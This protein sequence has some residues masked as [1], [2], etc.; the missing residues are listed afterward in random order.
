MLA[1]FWLKYLWRETLLRQSIQEKNKKKNF[2]FVCVGGDH[3]V[4]HV[5]KELL[6]ALADLDKRGHFLKI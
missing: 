3:F 6:C 1:L 4:V 5:K 2:S